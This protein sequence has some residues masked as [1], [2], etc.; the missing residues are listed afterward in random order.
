[1]GV[2][3]EGGIQSEAAA[4]RSSGIRLRTEH[5]SE[6]HASLIKCFYGMCGFGKACEREAKID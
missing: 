6:Q 3:K 1:M 5:W 2:I 4:D